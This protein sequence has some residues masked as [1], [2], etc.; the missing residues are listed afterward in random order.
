MS[1]GALA[2]PSKY[3][4]EPSRKIDGWSR[5][6]RETSAANIFSTIQAGK[7]L[8]ISDKK[9]LNETLIIFRRTDFDN[10]NMMSS[11]A[12]RATRFLLQ[13]DRITTSFADSKD[14]KG[15]LELVHESARMGIEYTVIRSTDSASEYIQ[16]ALSS[17]EDYSNVPLPISR[18]KK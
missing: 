18:K 13:I 12:T 6:I 10:L 16:S 1:Q 17:G 9:F 11:I 15:V 3:N 7:Y 5:F 14:P 2:L 4:L 8:E